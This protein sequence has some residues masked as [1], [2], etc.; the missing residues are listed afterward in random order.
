MSRK[1]FLSFAKEVSKSMA[2]QLAIANGVPEGRVM[3]W[4]QGV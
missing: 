3:R 2:I 4:A 1:M